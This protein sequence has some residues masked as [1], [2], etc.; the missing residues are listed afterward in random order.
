MPWFRGKCKSSKWRFTK[1]HLKVCRYSW[2]SSEMRWRQTGGQQTWIATL[3]ERTSANAGS[4]LGWIIL[5][6]L[7][8]L[9]VLLAN[10]FGQVYTLISINQVFENLVYKWQ[11]SLVCLSENPRW[12]P[13]RHKMLLHVHGLCLKTLIRITCVLVSGFVHKGYY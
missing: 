13:S 11:S 3:F 8:T 4:P 6:V 10:S 7:E 1:Q 9:I 12:I 5:V 2:A